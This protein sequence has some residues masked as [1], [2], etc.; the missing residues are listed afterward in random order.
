[1]KIRFFFFLSAALLFV[2]TGYAQ[3]PN[4]G[5]ENWESNGNPVDWWTNNAPGV[6]TTI[7]KTSDAHSGSWAVEGNVETVSGIGVGPAIISGVDGDGIP[8]NFRPVAITGYYKFT[9]IN[10]DYMQVQANLM[11]NGAGVGVGAANL[12]PA[13]SYSQFNIEIYY[14][15]EDVPD[16]AIIAVFIAGNGGFPNVG[17]KMFVDDLAWSNSTDVKD[18]GNG[19]PQNFELM[20]NFPNP[21]NPSTKIRY[22]IPEISFAT[23]KVYDMLGNE[24]ATLVDEEQAAGNY[25]TDFNAAGLS[26]GMYFYTLKAGNF[27]ETKK[28]LLLK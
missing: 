15:S 19:I 4:A 8:I 25:E 3:I 21:F 24:V 22:S 16:T 17:S 6:F 1:M 28:M 2:I 18:L 20:Q 23:I 9:S 26:S 11:K 27:V 12:N 14:I 5:F 13:G 10:S 7:T